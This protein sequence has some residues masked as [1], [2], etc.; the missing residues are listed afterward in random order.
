MRCAG[1]R[2]LVV[3]RIIDPPNHPDP[4]KVFDVAM[5]LWPGGRERDEGEWRALFNKSG[6]RLQRI[7]PTQGPHSI[8]E[9]LPA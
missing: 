2:V 9:G 1:G 4:K 6:F 7:I 8:M 3:D 5:M